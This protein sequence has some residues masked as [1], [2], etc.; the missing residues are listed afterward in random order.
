MIALVLLVVIATLLYL[1]QTV[2]GLFNEFGSMIAPYISGG[3]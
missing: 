3:S 1:G 2:E